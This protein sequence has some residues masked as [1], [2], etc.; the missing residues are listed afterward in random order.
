[1]VAH[2]AGN[3]L[4]SPNIIFIDKNSE[5]ETIF[6]DITPRKLRQSLGF[7]PVAV[8]CF[9]LC[10]A[11][12]LQWWPFTEALVPLEAK[13]SGSHDRFTAQGKEELDGSAVY[14]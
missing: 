1:M 5:K 8:L 13:G 7:I 6:E 3:S 4:G 14:G 10:P 2:K 11:T 12:S 9:L